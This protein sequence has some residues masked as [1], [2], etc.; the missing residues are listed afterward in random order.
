MPASTLSLTFKVDDA[1]GGFKK[2]TAD[3]DAFKK[4]MEASVTESQKLTTTINRFSSTALVFTAASDA[5]QQMNSAINSLT[6]A[7]ITTPQASL[8]FPPAVFSGMNLRQE[9]TAAYH[10]QLF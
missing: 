1:G 7:P 6:E 8:R 10:R 5:V 2:L 3:A 9:T 4:I